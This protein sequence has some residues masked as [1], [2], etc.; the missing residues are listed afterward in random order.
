MSSQISGR[1]SLVSRRGA[2]SPHVAV[3]IYNLPVSRVLLNLESLQPSKSSQISLKPL[4]CLHR[5]L[6]RCLI[7]NPF[8]LTIVSHNREPMLTPLIHLNLLHPL[9][10]HPNL[11]PQTSLQLLHHPDLQKILIPN[12]KIIRNIKPGDRFNHLI[13]ES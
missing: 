11:H 12:R 6:F 1:F 13:R 2:F 7:L 8:L 5:C 3:D 9:L 4:H 10:R